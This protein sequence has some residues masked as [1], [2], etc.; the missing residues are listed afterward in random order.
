MSANVRQTIAMS[1]A[2]TPDWRGNQEHSSQE[3]SVAHKLELG[4]ELKFVFDKSFFVG[5]VFVAAPILA[6]ALAT[7]RWSV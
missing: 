3:R 2:R 7:A 5:M 1:Q 6:F 4:N